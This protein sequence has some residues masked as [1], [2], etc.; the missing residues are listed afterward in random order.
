LFGRLI[1]W[2]DGWLVHNLV[3]WVRLAGS[4][5]LGQIG[6]ARLVGWLVGWLALLVG[7]LVGLFI[8]W[9]VGWL[10]GWFVNWLGGQVGW[11]RLVGRLVGWFHTFRCYS[12]CHFTYQSK[13]ASSAST[14]RTFARTKQFNQ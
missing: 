10:V 13:S 12:G 11:A 3:G 1:E 5:W 14:V 2:L 7:W 8:V 4:G 9:L 6:W